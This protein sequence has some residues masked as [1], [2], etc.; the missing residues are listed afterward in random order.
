MLK[1]ENIFAILLTS[2]EAGAVVEITVGHPDCIPEG[3]RVKMAELFARANYLT[4]LYV[5]LWHLKNCVIINFLII[6]GFRMNVHTGYMFYNAAVDVS[7]C[8]DAD[9][10]LMLAHYIRWC[11]N[12][13][14]KFRS[15]IKAVLNDDNANVEALVLEADK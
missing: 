3:K 10:L 5:S 6:G 12:A 15:C 4:L 13:W 1:S 11:T 7:E 14:Q 9:V 8:N 2:K